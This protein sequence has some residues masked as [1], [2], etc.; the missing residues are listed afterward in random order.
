MRK[1]NGVGEDGQRVARNVKRLRQQ[2]RISLVEMA[3]RLTEIGRPIARLG[4]YDIER[5]QRRVDIDDLVA[6]AQA[7]RVPPDRL[8]FD[9]DLSVE[10]RVVVGET[11]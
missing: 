1:T 5:G 11:R 8:A 2:Q 9:D 10:V 3:T 7:L 4:L 6:L